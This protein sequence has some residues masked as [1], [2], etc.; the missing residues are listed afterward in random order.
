MLYLVTRT[1]NASLAP[2]PKWQA[3]A[4]RPFSA[5]LT[6]CP[7]NFNNCPGAICT[8]EGSTRRFELLAEHGTGG[9]SI[10]RLPDP[11]MKQMEN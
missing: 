10:L 11:M 2:P 4:S 6:M 1:R 5:S 9:K 3:Q 8:N 7:S